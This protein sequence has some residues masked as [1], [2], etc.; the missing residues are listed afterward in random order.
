MLAGIQII[1]D[2]DTRSTSTVL[3]GEYMGQI[4]QTNDGRTFRYGQNGSTSTALSPGKLAQGATA[5]AG[6]LNKTGATYAAGTSVVTLT[7]SSTAVTADEYRG[8]YFNVN[9]GTG[10]GQQ[11][12]I[13]GNTKATS[14]GS[15]TVYLKDAIIT[16]TLASDSKFSLYPHPYSAAIISDHTAPT[17][18]IPLGV[19]VVSIAASAAAF[20]GGNS[21]WFQTAG[22]AAVLANGTI[23]LGVSVIPGAT[24]DGS[25]DTA[26]GAITQSFVGYTLV[27]SVSTEYRPVFLTINQL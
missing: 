17:T 20:P 7:V 22:P 4:A 1:T 11:L 26:T 19:P 15:P 2:Q 24:T 13:R 18:V 14:T 6:H 3:G 5:V 10:A 27:A 23:A 21:G 8:G 9:A 12:L 16:A 25:V